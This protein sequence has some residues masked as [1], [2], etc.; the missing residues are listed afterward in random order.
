M[1]ARLQM[2]LG[3]ACL[4][5]A[6]DPINDR[7]DVHPADKFVHFF[8]HL[9]APHGDSDQALVPDQYRHDVELS[10]KT[11]DTAHE[12]NRPTGPSRCDRATQRAFATDFDDQI[13]AASPVPQGRLRVSV[14][15][16]FGRHCVAPV[17]LEL[18]RQFPELNVEMSFSDHVVDL[19]DEGFDLAVRIGTLP[20]SAS[21]AARRL[22]HRRMAICAAPSYL[23]ERGRPK[24]LEDLQTHRAIAYSR[25]GQIVPWRVRGEDG[26]LE[27][28]VGSEI[29]FDD[30]QV[31]H[32]AAVSGAGLPWLPCWLVA[33]QVRTGELALVM[34]SDRVLSADIHAVWPNARYMPAKTRAAVDLLAA[35]IPGML[36]KPRVSQ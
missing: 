34:D 28:R 13:R 10:G 6:E 21:L 22:G 8:E 36:T 9:P 16:L 27:V 25:G 4:L 17:V 26:N 7:P 12:N 18:A 15:T 11:S 32:D 29:V 24:G 19:V 14:P 23:D 35:R 5:K 30:L 31:I 33:P 3:L 2:S 1:A 20:D